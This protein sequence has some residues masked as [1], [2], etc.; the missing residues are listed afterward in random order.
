MKNRACAV[1]AVCAALGSARGD[2]VLWSGRALPAGELLTC[3]PEGMIFEDQFGVQRTVRWDL[4]KSLSGPEAQAAAGYVETART[5]WRARTRLERGDAVSA[6]PLFEQLYPQ[7]EGREGEMAAL[8]CEGLLRCRLR[9]S[10]HTSAVR[11]WLAYLVARPNGPYR[12]VVTGALRAACDEQTGLVPSL[13]P[14]W[15]STPAVEAFARSGELVGWS[16]EG[17]QLPRKAEVFSAL[18]LHAA[19]FECGLESGP[20]SIDLS[21]A[22]LR[23]PG[24][25]LVHAMVV[26]RT[27]DAEQRTGARARL[28]QIMQSGTS[29]RPWIEAWCRLAIG[30]SLL[31]ESD[32]EQRRLG[33]VELLHL[34]ARFADSLPYLAGQA[35]AEAVVA[36]D[37]MGDAGGA[38]SLLAELSERYGSHA[39]LSWQPMRERLEG[40]GGAPSGPRE[41]P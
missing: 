38:S 31:R 34:P 25:A 13:A 39:V 22:D 6:E 32:A 5:A 2:V 10:A 7:Y 1:L 28:S 19:R 17:G 30:R 24:V 36:L 16:A 8:V 37:E 15:E 20:P 40:T 11:P 23:D 33:V 4:V 12:S 18:F 27:G 21:N 35:L 9:R 14:V 29:D 41:K 3:T 26:S